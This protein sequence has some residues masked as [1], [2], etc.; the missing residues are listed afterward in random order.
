VPGQRLDDWSLVTAGLLFP[1]A[2]FL[3]QLGNSTSIITRTNSANP[4]TA[5]LAKDVASE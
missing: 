1:F 3:E 2:S 5:S 4:E